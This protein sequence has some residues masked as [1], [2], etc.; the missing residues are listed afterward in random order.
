MI[1]QVMGADF[2]DFWKVSL[3]LSHFIIIIFLI[4]NYPLHKLPDDAWTYSIGNF[5]EVIWK[6]HWIGS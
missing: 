6:E 1:T 2:C 5:D 3:S 4:L